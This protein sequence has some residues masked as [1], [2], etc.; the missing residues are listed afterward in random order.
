MP[1]RCARHGTARRRTRAFA[2]PS[3]TL[4]PGG[5]PTCRAL[6]TAPIGVKRFL[7][8]MGKWT[9]WANMDMSGLVRL[10]LDGRMLLQ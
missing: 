10:N 5:N 4:S 8:G 2:A 9:E 7:Q 3:P 1:G 6:R